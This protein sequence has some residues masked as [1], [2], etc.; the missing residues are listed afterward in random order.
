MAVTKSKKAIIIDYSGQKLRKLNLS[1]VAFDDLLNLIIM[2][3][4]ENVMY[5]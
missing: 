1:F 5:F 3:L 4:K 2:V